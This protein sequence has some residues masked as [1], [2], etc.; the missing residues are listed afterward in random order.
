[1]SAI[2]PI[3][4]RLTTGPSLAGDVNERSFVRFH[5]SEVL[6]DRLAWIE[7]WPD[8]VSS[9]CPVVGIHGLGSSAEDLRPVAAR[10]EAPSVLIDLPGFGRSSRPDRTYPVGRA[11]AAVVALLDAIGVRRAVLLGCSYGGHVALRAALDA[12]DRV[13]GLVL[14]A[15]GGLDPSPPA[16]LIAAYD[17]AAMMS[18]PLTAVA[19]ACS[20]L[21]ASPNSETRRFTERRLAVHAAAQSGASESAHDYRAIARSVDG[22][23]RD[24]AAR[25]LHRVAAPVE[26]V[27][28]AH[29]PLVAPAV[30]ERASRRLRD[31]TLTVLPAS[32]HVP[33]LEEPDAV[34]A[35][36]RRALARVRPL[37]AE[38]SQE[39]DR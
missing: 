32:G 30:V 27:H 8:H 13:A 20:A 22:A 38:T 29:D 26:L 33:W 23:I 31:A 35:R 11:S 15:S 12:P 14:V 18:R 9:L 4:D 2:A 34:A 28:G 21:I 39:I 36:V 10:L 1:M 16:E 19:A 25:Q 17:Q 37:R 3:S 7:T 6:G 24:D 5:E